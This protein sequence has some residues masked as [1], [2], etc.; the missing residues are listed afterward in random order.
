MF[1][2]ERVEHLQLPRGED[3]ITVNFKGLKHIK[4]PNPSTHPTPLFF[5]ETGKIK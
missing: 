3:E 5:Y 2:S 4:L 1:L